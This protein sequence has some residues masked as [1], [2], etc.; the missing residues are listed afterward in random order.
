MSTIKVGD[1]VKVSETPDVGKYDYGNGP[2]WTN[3]MDV[4]K[5]QTGEVIRLNDE[6]AAK[7]KFA[8]SSSWYFLPADLTL[9][10][11]PAFKI[12]DR[13][14]ITSSLDSADYEGN[15]APGM[16]GFAGK[17]GVV[18]SVTSSRS[19]SVRV[20]ELLDWWNFNAAD[21]TLVPAVQEATL[22][23]GHIHAASML[24]YAQDAAETD[25]PW[26]RWETQNKI[27][28]AWVNLGNSPY[29]SPEKEYRRKPITIRIGAFDVPMPLRVAPE[30]GT[31]YFIL[32]LSNGAGKNY[33][34][35]SWNNDSVDRRWLERGI[36]H[37]TEE[38]AG[39]HAKALLSFSTVA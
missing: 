11:A 3:S 1:R 27:S 18:Q 29:W 36:S 19:I 26:L 38:A 25:K 28:P 8:D 30:M 12:G 15:W 4:R 20:A 37:L 34:A 5:G 9:S 23:T 32:D 16:A 22:P 6:G 24:L 33:S 2:G 7:V 39:L 21:L 31:Q 13:V 17:V 35:T 10:P 14:L